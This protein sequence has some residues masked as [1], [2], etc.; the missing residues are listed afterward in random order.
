[1]LPGGLEKQIPYWPS[2]WPK[3]WNCEFKL[4]APYKTTIEGNVANGR[5]VDLKV[6]PQSRRQD[7]IVV[8]KE[9]R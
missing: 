1:M 2:A 9:A 7:V 6:T 5:V 8:R 3:D 4:N